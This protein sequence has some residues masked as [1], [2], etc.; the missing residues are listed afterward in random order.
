[1]HEFG[2]ALTLEKMTL[3]DTLNGLA[4]AASS[5]A[6]SE[7]H[8]YIQ[9]VDVEGRC[10]PKLLRAHIQPLFDAS[11][12]KELVHAIKQVQKSL[13]ALGVYKDVAISLNPDRTIKISL[14]ATGR[15]MARV[16]TDM[17]HSEGS[18]YIRGT[19]C[20]NSGWG[21]VI[22]VDTSAGTR[23]KSSHLLS[24]SLPIPFAK[25]VGWKF[26][27]LAYSSEKSLE[28]CSSKAYVKGITTRLSK[29][30]GSSFGVDAVLRT[31]ASTQPNSSK[32]VHTNAGNDFKFSIF[33]N[34]RFDNRTVTDTVT[35][36]G[37]G[38]MIDVHNELAMQPSSSPFY[39]FGA[40]FQSAFKILKPLTGALNAKIG[41]VLP[42]GSKHRVHHLDK[43][44][45]GGSLDLRGFR[46]NHAGPHEGC[47][48]EG[49]N[50]LAAAG[51][52]IFSPIP[53]VDSPN[54]KFHNFLNVGM[55]A[56]LSARFDKTMLPSI[57][58]GSGIL[59]THPSARFELNIAVPIVA[60]SKELVH[61]GLQFG[62][63]LEFL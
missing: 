23:T 51:L 11:N 29:G 40:K 62:V 47:D 1:M 53:R 6:G 54:L 20:N 32:F 41:M 30:V 21:E 5:V 60:H 31:L 24:G 55:L 18:G 3:E 57:S 45:L 50:Y 33:H 44:N 63:G 37:A 49:G 56:P 4:S 28:W 17:G 42:V 15:F 2:A 27:A 7:G 12:V 38:Y 43:L 36:N 19:M 8:V 34:W 26:E 46:L 35:G 22:T 13:F 58:V 16:G 59:Y 48:A 39:K 25:A 10:A 52:S 9:G 61:K 14:P